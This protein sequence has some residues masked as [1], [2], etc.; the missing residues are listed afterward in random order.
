MEITPPARYY[1]TNTLIL[2]L[3]SGK[4]KP[5]VDRFLGGTI[6][7]TYAL[8]YDCIYQWTRIS[9]IFRFMSVNL[10]HMLIV[11]FTCIFH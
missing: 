11:L 3:W 10:G 2:A 7:N 4:N 1:R 8:W 6:T 5:D 9:A